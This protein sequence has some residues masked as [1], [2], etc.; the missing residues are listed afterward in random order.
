M[1]TPPLKFGIYPFATVGM[2]EGSTQG[3]PDDFERL[4]RAVMELSGGKPFLPR[5]YLPYTGPNSAA[6]VLTHVETLTRIGIPWDLVL[7]YRDPTS[8]LRAWTDLLRTVVR[9]FGHQLDALQITNEANLKGLPGAA[10]GSHPAIMAALVE[11]ILT[12]HDAV[13]SAGA[14]VQIG[15]SAVPERP[16]DDFWQRLREQ[17][18][19]D[20]P[21]AL[22]YVGYDFYPG[23]FGPPVALEMLEETVRALLQQLRMVYLPTAGIPPNVPIRIAENGWPT[24]PDR[25]EAVQAQALE[26]IIRTIDSLREPLHIT[27]YELFGLR[28]ADSS[29]PDKF[30]RFGLLHDDYSPKPA[31]ET[32]R[33]LIEELG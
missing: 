12:A 14:T 28:D 29:N 24:G 11:G 4:G 33:R 30:H 7:C 21:A 26:T 15:F 23:V 32:Y 27:H 1:T 10:D 9:R 22:D 13:E 17:G 3:P 18:G 2:A 16:G 8:D 5:T 6:Y 19:S 20:F 25:S 31:F